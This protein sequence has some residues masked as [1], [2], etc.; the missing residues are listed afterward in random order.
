MPQQEWEVVVYRSFPV[1]QV[2]MADAASFDP[3]QR[4]AGTRV[5]NQNRFY[6]DWRAFRTRH[7]PVHLVDHEKLL[8]FCQIRS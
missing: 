6:A 7:N 3:D 4:F 2:S 8:M 5:G 1:M